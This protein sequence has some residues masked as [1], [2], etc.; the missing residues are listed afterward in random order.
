MTPIHDPASTHQQARTWSSHLGEL[1]AST[2]PMQPTDPAPS[3]LAA[4][5]ARFRRRL[6]GQEHTDRTMKANEFLVG[7]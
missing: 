7:D 4:I 5:L 1:A 6:P 2:V 3:P